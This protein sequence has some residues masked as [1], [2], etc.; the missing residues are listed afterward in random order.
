MCLQTIIMIG[1]FFIVD[2]LRQICEINDFMKTATLL[3]TS[4]IFENFKGI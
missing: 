3:P 2:M 4:L 1:I